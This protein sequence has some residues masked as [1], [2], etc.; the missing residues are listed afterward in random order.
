[1]TENALANLVSDDPDRIVTACPLCLDTF[2]RY[3]D[4]PVED[5]S[6]VIDR[7]SVPADKKRNDN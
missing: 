6:Q 7:V 4:R 2:A 3:S 5:I 1:M